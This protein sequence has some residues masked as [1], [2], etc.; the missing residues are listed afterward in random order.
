[1]VRLL[2][3]DL[4]GTAVCAILPDAGDGVFRLVYDPGKPDA[5]RHAQAM[6]RDWWESFLVPEMYPDGTVEFLNR[7]CPEPASGPIRLVVLPTA[8]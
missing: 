2:G 4:P 7:I 6:F 1:M 5:F 3:R 8:S